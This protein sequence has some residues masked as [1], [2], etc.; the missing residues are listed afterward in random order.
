MKKE[1]SESTA[2]GLLPFSLAFPPYFIA[3]LSGSSFGGLANILKTLSESER[4]ELASF[5]KE[6][7]AGYLLEQEHKYI[8]AE[9]LYLK[10][11]DKYR[12]FA[13]IALERIQWILNESKQ[14]K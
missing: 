12:K 2:L 1:E 4:L 10:L 9:E 6:Y 13:Y 14:N 5:E 3:Y 8:E 11:A 7:R